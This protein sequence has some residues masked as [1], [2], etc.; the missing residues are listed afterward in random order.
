MNQLHTQQQLPQPDIERLEPWMQ[1]IADEHSQVPPFQQLARN[2]YHHA[3]VAQSDEK[4]VVRTVH[5]KPLGNAVD[6]VQGTLKPP[7]EFVR[8]LVHFTITTQHRPQLTQKWMR[9]AV[10]PGDGYG[11]FST[12]AC[13]GALAR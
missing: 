3:R 4:A 13:T 7:A 6:E 8:R 10:P 1:H 12:V 5:T 2:R 9:H 11:F